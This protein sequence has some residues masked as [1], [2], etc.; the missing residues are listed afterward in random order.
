MKLNKNEE[1]IIITALK[2]LE[3]YFPKTFEIKEIELDGKYGFNHI[4]YGPSTIGGFFT[5]S[6]TWEK[7]DNK[8]D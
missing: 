8:N 7:G 2:T 6:L 5:E 3:K 4:Y 1:Q